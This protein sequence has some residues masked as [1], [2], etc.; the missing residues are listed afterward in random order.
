MST[1]VTT[2]VRS[3]EFVF[4][5]TTEEIHPEAEWYLAG[6]KASTL[7]K[8]VFKGDVQIG[9]RIKFDSDYSNCSP[10][11]KPGL[12]YLFFAYKKEDKYRVYACT[13]WGD[14]D[15]KYTQR[16]IRKIRKYVK[17][18]RETANT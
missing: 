9:Q 4:L 5:V 17:R 7:V 12:T 15:S 1:D 10:K 16:D 18:R 11:F 8:E 2:Y 6:Y 13:P 3:S 14:V